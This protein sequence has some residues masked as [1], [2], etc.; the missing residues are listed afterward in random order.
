MNNTIRIGLI[1]AGGNT[2]AKHIPEFLAIPDVEIVA[3]ANRTEES[4][5]TVSDEFNLSARITVDP[6]E[7]INDPD[8]DAICIGTWPYKHREFTIASLNAGKHVLVE[9]RMS[10]NAKEAEEMLDTAQQ[11]PNLISQ[12]VPAPMD[13]GS[14]RTIKRLVNE[15]ENGDLGT[16]RET[17]FSVL[18]GQ[19]LNPNAPLHWRERTEYSGMNVMMYGIAVEIMERWLGPTE[20]VIAD[21]QTT[22]N[23]KINPDTNSEIA[24]EIPDSLNVIA[25]QVNG[26]RVIYRL[27]TIT[28]DPEGTSGAV[29]YG[30]NGTLKWSFSTDTL[31]F[32]P[33]GGQA[34][35]MPHDEGTTAGWQVEVDFINSIRLGNPVI[36]TNFSD[37]LNYMK[38]LEATYHARKDGRRVVIE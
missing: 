34:A 10:M 26:S 19:G 22:I 12:I 31:E 1:G 33:L 18:S 6:L 25:R 37:G 8:I 27:S 29:I 38:V 7:V 9:A 3:I 2:R 5:K 24:I 11:N 16:I 14:W 32:T 21:G 23:K 13:F 20:S 15:G 28:N 17:H 36:L 4:A 35:P 30:S